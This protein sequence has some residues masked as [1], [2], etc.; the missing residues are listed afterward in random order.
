MLFESKIEHAGGMF[1]TPVWAAGDLLARGGGFDP[2]I[3]SRDL[4][5]QEGILFKHLLRLILLCQEFSQLTP[6]DTT[7]ESWQA[8]LK[9]LSD[10]LSTACRTVDPQ[11]TDE[12]LEE[13]AEGA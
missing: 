2:F 6:R 10:A 13:I 5:K 4:V 3:R 7:A 11:C 1:I 9:T 8:A 12:T